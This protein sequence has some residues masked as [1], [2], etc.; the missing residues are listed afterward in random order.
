MLHW[1]FN[2][3]A[4]RIYSF[5]APVRYRFRANTDYK[6]KLLFFQKQKR[7]SS[8]T[9]LAENRR[10]S[11]IRLRGLTDDRSLTDQNPFTSPP[12]SDKYLADNVRTKYVSR[13]ELKTNKKMFLWKI[14][15]DGRFEYGCSATTWIVTLII[16]LYIMPFQRATVSKLQTLLPYYSTCVIFSIL[17]LFLIRIFFKICINNGLWLATTDIYDFFP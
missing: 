4:I 7:S 13:G 9:R 12:S 10:T 16:K 3:N 5:A 11:Y 15:Y 1:R 8:V 17:R 14:V 2:V 6:K